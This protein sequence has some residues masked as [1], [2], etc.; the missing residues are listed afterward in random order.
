MAEHQQEQP[1]AV[2]FGFPRKLT[3]PTPAPIRPPRA[4]P[5]SSGNFF[6]MAVNN[7]WTLS[8]DFAD[9]SINSNPA[10]PAYASASEVSTAR[11]AERS[12]LL[13]ANAIMMASGACRWSS[14]IHAFALSREDY[15]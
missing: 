2:V 10:S 3:L 12:H 9:V 4:L 7:S 5:L 8:P 13:P 1:C 11:W 14:F 15:C 6:A